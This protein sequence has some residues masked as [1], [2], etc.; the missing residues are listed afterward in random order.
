[1]SH[2]HTLAL[3]LAAGLLL[4]AVPAQAAGPAASPPSAD[5]EI[6]RSISGAEV[7]PEPTPEPSSEPSSEPS[8]EPPAAPAPDPDWIPG[9]WY[10]PTLLAL[11]NRGINC[12]WDDGYLHAAK[13][14]TL[15][16]FLR[17]LHRATGRAVEEGSR[18]DSPAAH[19]KAAQEDGLFSAQALEQIT[20]ES[21]LTRFEAARLLYL[22]LSGQDAQHPA[23]PY[24]SLFLQDFDQV[25]TELRKAVGSLYTLGILRGGKQRFRGE[26]TL[27]RAEGLTAVLRLI[28]P[29]QR[30]WPLQEV[31]EDA[32]ILRGELLAAVNQTLGSQVRG[33]G[34]EEAFLNHLWT[35]ERLGYL[36][37]GWLAPGRLGSPV[38]RYELSALFA[39]LLA[40]R[41]EGAEDTRAA[42]LYLEEFLPIPE[43]F[44]ED[45]AQCV[46]SGVTAPERFADYDWNALVTQGEFYAMLER[47]LRP[48]TRGEAPM[49][50]FTQVLGEFTTHFD[51][52]T[53][54]AFNI[55]RSAQ[56]LDRLVLQPGET[57]SFNAVTGPA[58][59]IHG[60]KM[61]TVLSGGRYVPGWGGGVCQTSTTLFNA[62]L[63]S[64]L[65]IVERHTHSLK[66]AYVDYGRDATVSSPYLD[67][68]LRNPY[69]CPVKVAARWGEGY[70]TFYILAPG[71][72]SLPQIVLS[73]ENTAPHSYT[74]TRTSNGVV[75]Y[76]AASTYRN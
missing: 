44:Q 49:G 9:R 15:G 50:G 51:D 59:G 33:S 72:L 8:Q 28:E 14:M 1:M 3:L 45:A 13:E 63:L 75:D 21:P 27:T 76:T 52:T 39:R 30:F 53:N 48:E 5:Q 11:T 41:G 2:R 31:Q 6:D 23:S 20:P 61:S 16:D 46:L 35:A 56:L 18:E 12:V 4:G 54:S 68:S 34:K 43:Q 57:M 47:L 73:V 42:R 64:G 36:P 60:Y 22:S 10:Y 17:L 29:A 7:T 38:T 58:D 66:S 70:V 62:A 40:L 24:I 74:L 69:D 65:T 67:L 32:S 25:P 71:S 55:K 26:R 19:L 37:A